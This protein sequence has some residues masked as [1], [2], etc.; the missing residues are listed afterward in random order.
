MGFFSK[1]FGGGGTQPGPK[2]L[3]RFDSSSTSIEVA[4]AGWANPMTG[5]GEYGLDPT[6]KPHKLDSTATQQ[7]LGYVPR[8]SLK[9]LLEELERYGTAGPPAPCW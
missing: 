2:R 5:L 7:W 1:V 4:T 8:Y 9:N 6:A 3:R